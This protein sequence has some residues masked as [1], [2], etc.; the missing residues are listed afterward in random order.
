MWFHFRLVGQI[1]AIGTLFGKKVCGNEQGV[2][3]SGNASAIE[4]KNT[5]LRSEDEGLEVVGIGLD[6]VIAIAMPDAVLVANATRTQE[7]RKV[8]DVLKAKKAHQAEAFPIDHRPWGWFESLVM[9]KRFQVKRIVVHPG[10]SLFPCNRII[11][12]PNIGSLLKVRQR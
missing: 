10:G 6:N 11:I 9:G 4:C 7:V 5:L 1:W 12:D 2:A 3:I 8:I